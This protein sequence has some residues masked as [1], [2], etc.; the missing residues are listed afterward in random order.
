MTDLV[1]VGGKL[2]AICAVAA[3]A[4]GLVNSVTAPA[5]ARVKAEQLAAAL[6]SVRGNAVA[7]GEV[8]VE[9]DDFVAGYYP[10]EQGGNSAG[11]VLKII[12]VGYGGD[13]ELLASFQPDGLIRRVTLMDN[14]ETP[15]LGKAAEKT[16]YME[17]FI[18]TGAAKAVPLTKL[19]LTQ[20]QAD[21]VSG[22]SITF[23]GVAQALD[24]GS[25]FVQESLG[26][27]DD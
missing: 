6:D 1:T 23:M 15:G 9:D 25:R 14:L 24:E 10:L 13:L 2:A 16:E 18:G 5:I 26:K 17:K 21:S 3:I 11:Y 20:E 4:L 12:G 19:Q 8:I 22:A 7:G 27:Q